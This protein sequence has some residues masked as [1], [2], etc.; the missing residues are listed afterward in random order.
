M[1]RPFFPDSSWKTGGTACLPDCLP[2]WDPRHSHGHIHNSK[3]CYVHYTYENP[4]KTCW[5][6]INLLVRLLLFIFAGIFYQPLG[7][8]IHQFVEDG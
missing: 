8:M 2:I 1:Q 3:T 7:D 4:F 5:V 6:L